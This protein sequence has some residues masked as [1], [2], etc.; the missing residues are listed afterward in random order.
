MS[1]LTEDI[2]THWQAVSP[3]FVI[4][5]ENDYDRAIELLNALIDEVGVDEQHPLYDMLDTLG[6]VVH[7]YE[8]EHYPIPDADAVG[9]LHFL[10]EEHNLDIHNLSEIG[11][12][13][14][15]SDILERKRE[16][17]VKNIQDLAKRFQV[18]P[19]VFV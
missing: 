9:V 17:T 4:R 14:T 11:T 18:S 5:N 13:D 16:L 3:L 2:Q 6:T 19:A 8:E 1:M 10:M 12:P 7:A 15:V